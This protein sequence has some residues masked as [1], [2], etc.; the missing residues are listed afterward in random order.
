MTTMLSDGHAR[1]YFAIGLFK[2]RWKSNLKNGPVRWRNDSAQKPKLVEKTIIV[3]RDAP[4][5]KVLTPKEAAA[6]LIKLRG[7]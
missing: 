3:R 2:T 1:E 7:G 5:P 4:Q 6:R